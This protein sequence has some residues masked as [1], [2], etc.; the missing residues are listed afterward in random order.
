[1]LIS[2]FARAAGLTM[3]TVRYYIR[4][5]LLTPETNGL[6]GRNAYQIF[7][8]EH[9][10]IAR[11]IRLA[12]SL[13]LSLKDIAAIG[14]EDRAG[15]ISTERSIEIMSTQLVRLEQKAAEL[16]SMAAYLR[17][18]IAWLKG[19][20]QGPEPELDGLAIDGLQGACT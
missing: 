7:T 14:E 19:G 12:Q 4:R 15:G 9:V 18:K 16:A 20:Q 8:G 3:D 11:I 10:R 13:G 5:G 1:M 2:E 6:G 17:A